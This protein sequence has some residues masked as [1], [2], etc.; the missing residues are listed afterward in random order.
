MSL[1]ELIVNWDFLG[2]SHEWISHLYIPYV[3]EEF[4]FRV[5]NI[6]HN[7]HH[8][9]R[10]DGLPNAPVSLCPQVPCTQ[11]FTTRVTNPP[12]QNLTFLLKFDEYLTWHARDIYLYNSTLEFMLKCRLFFIS[13]SWNSRVTTKR[14][15]WSLTTNVHGVTYQRRQGHRCDK[16]NP[17]SFY[18]FLFICLHSLTSKGCHTKWD[19]AGNKTLPYIS[20][21]TRVTLNSLK[22]LNGS[23]LLDKTSFSS[24]TLPYRVT[25]E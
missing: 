16:Q 7:I 14:S 21:R 18:N 4:A 10:T 5:T 12:V 17:P 22:R 2:N 6:S 25:G 1:R 8:F 20:Q 19:L 24:V 15:R 3:A 9:L 13:C 11:G 23:L